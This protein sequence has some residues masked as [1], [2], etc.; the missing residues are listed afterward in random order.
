MAGPGRP[1]SGALMR[2]RLTYRGELKAS[3]LDPLTGQPDRLAEHKQKIR[4][5]FHLQLKHLWQTN[6]FLRDH[7]TLPNKRPDYSP[8][9]PLA[10]WIDDSEKDKIPLVEEIAS[11]FHENGYRFVPLVCED[12]SLLCSLRILFLRRDPP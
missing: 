5:E 7:K 3:Q 8:A 10:M 12:M 2:F 4:K 11:N 9:T 1:G 6:K